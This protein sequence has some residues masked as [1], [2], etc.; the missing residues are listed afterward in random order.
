MLETLLNYDRELFLF[1]NNLGSETWDAFWMT[2]TTKFYWIPFYS[3]LLFFIW[4]RLKNKKAMVIAILVIIAMVA[5]TDQITNLF[6]HGFQRLRPCHDTDL[7]GLMRV[8]RKGCG[9]RF[10]FFS[11]H[12]SNSM[13]V[14]IF[15]GMMIKYNYKNAIYL[16]IVWSLVMGY[17]RIYVGVHYPLDVVCGLTFGAISGYLFYRLFN[18]LKEKYATSL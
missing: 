18:Y 3:L 8:V 6:K 15:V 11:G 12:S 5:F 10:G 7:D 13:A 2:Y 9:G 14:A 4:K 17:S 1:L 16:L